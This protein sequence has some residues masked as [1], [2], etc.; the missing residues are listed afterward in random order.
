MDALRPSQSLTHNPLAKPVK[1]A[2][3][4]KPVPSAAAACLGRKRPQPLTS[5]PRPPDRPLQTRDYLQAFAKPVMHSFAE[6]R[7]KA[8]EPLRVLPAPSL[9]YITAS[10]S[11][12]CKAQALKY[13]LVP[14]RRRAAAQSNLWRPVRPLAAAASKRDIGCEA[15]EDAD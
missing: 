6:E 9:K 1:L 12:R 8:A 15:R 7:S 3:L 13:R 5:K 11:V 2:R 14:P 10:F 4:L